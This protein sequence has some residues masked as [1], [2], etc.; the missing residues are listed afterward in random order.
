[1]SERSSGKGGRQA[2]ECS[3]I[4]FLNFSDHF[5]YIHLYH[6]SIVNLIPLVWQQWHSRDPTLSPA[7]V[8]WLMN[9]TPARWIAWNTQSTARGFAWFSFASHEATLG[10]P[11]FKA[12]IGKSKIKFT[13][14]CASGKLNNNN[15]QLCMLFVHWLKTTRTYTGVVGYGSNVR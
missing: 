4:R 8:F 10:S 6:T 3:R 15:S 7:R 9:R 5:V 1:M 11:L 2:Q 12:C 14:L 13:G